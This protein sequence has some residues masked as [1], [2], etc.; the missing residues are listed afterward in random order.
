ME[1]VEET[2]WFQRS[3]QMNTAFPLHLSIQICNKITTLICM[4]LCS[5]NAHDFYLHGNFISTSS[6]PKVVELSSGSSEAEA[7]AA[8]AA[9]ETSWGWRRNQTFSELMWN[10]GLW[11]LNTSCSGGLIFLDC[12]SITF[13]SLLSVWRSRIVRSKSSSL[14]SISTD[15]CLVSHRDDRRDGWWGLGLQIAPVGVVTSLRGLEANERPLDQVW[16]QTGGWL[17]EMASSS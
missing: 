10:C 6:S 5:I 11:T 17:S 15:A 9:S 4:L 7:V 1:G 2:R 8:S 13:E 14:H 3:L 16:V 12:V